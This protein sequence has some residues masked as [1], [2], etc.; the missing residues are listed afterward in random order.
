MADKTYIS[1]YIESVT[2]E[3]LYAM[4]ERD[5]RSVSGQIGWLIE[6]EHERRQQPARQLVDQ[7]VAYSVGTPEEDR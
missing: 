3:R 2:K 6:R 4:A 5:H 7:G 1:A